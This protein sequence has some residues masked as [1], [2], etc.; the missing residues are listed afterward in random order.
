M[1]Q[2]PL[3]EGLGLVRDHWFRGEGYFVALQDHLLLEDLLLGQVVSE[4]FHA[5]EHFIEDHSDA[6]NVHF[7][8]DDRRGQPLLEHLGGQVPVGAH[9]LGGQG[10]LTTVLLHDLAQ[11]E[12]SDLHFPLVEQDVLGLQVV[13]DDALPEVMQVLQ[14]THY[15]LQNDL[16]LEFSQYLVLLEV[17]VQV[18]AFAEFQHSAHGVIVYYEAP[19]QEGDDVGVGQF[20]VGV[21]FPL[22][23][24]DILL[25][26]G[27]VPV[28]RQ[29]AYL[30][31]HLLMVEEVEGLVD[32]PEA[33]LADETEYL[34][35]VL[36]EGPGHLE[37]GGTGLAEL[38][39]LLLVDLLEL[40]LEQH[41]LI[42]HT[43]VF[44]LKVLFLLLV[45]DQV[46]VDLLLEG[47]Q[48]LPRELLVLLVLELFLLA[49]D[50]LPDGLEF[51]GL[52]L[53]LDPVFPPVHQLVVHH[54]L[55]ELAV[56][57][58]LLVD[59]LLVDDPL[60]LLVL[61]Q[62][63]DQHLLTFDLVLLEGLFLLLHHVV[64]LEQ[65]L[66]LVVEDVLLLPQSLLTDLQLC[67]HLLVGLHETL[68]TLVVVLHLVLLQQLGLPLL[69]VG[70]GGPL[71]LALLEER[72]DLLLL[73]ETLVLREQVSRPLLRALLLSVLLSLL[74]L[75]RPL[76][77]HTLPRLVVRVVQNA[78]LH[79]L[80][81]LF[82]K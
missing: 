47:L 57:A 15:L 23:V 5:V 68:L 70:L 16:G 73:G 46:E 64:R 41:L 24:F 32:L 37:V 27:L 82:Y 74:L 11:A 22:Y 10:Q 3:D 1:T 18:R 81:H 71:L 49:V 58:L 30:D 54:P 39:V 76:F 20:Q 34:V 72:G 60:L 14:A 79:L 66:L 45:D 9:P 28:G 6:P 67:F 40:V 29:L 21:H 59:P 80:V 65:L 2:T 51:L 61:Q 25:T 19:V 17:V 48:F 52:L 50:F 26:V 69:L 7:G 38:A 36:E 4:G 8:A 77:V 13:V 78:H 33:A 53:D 31:S 12:V 62:V 44:L 63:L 56:L 42:L 55:D 43:V 75:L 35:P